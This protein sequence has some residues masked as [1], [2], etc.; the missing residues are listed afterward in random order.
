MLE[1][2]KNKTFLLGAC[3]ALLLTGCLQV[4]TEVQVQSD[5]SG[6]VVERLL[7][8]KSFIKSMAASFG[9]GGEQK[10]SSSNRESAEKKAAKMGEGVTL[11]QTEAVDTEDFTGQ[12]AIYHFDDI[13]KLKLSQSKDGVKD[14]IRF[15]FKPGETSMLTILMPETRPKED[16]KQQADNDQSSSQGE[17][18][19]KSADTEQMKALFKDMRFTM[20]VAPQGIVTAT[21]ASHLADNKITL[22][23][24]DFGQLLNIPEALSS[25]KAQNPQ[26]PAEAALLANG[27]PGIKVELQKQIEVHFH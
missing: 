8:S 18:S 2:V 13:N 3:L 22:V 14:P 20:T 6:Y 9:K 23:D 12:V 17:S 15:N 19:S 27:I 10:L 16:K 25:L 26:S 11:T 7:I 5:G 24:F 4:D 21:N 1:F